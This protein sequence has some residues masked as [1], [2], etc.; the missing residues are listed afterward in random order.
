MANL[1]DVEGI[2]RGTDT[3]HVHVLHTCVRCATGPVFRQSSLLCGTEDLRC[4]CVIVA[5]LQML[6]VVGVTTL[7]LHV[8]GL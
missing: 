7:T 4:M 2:V 8:R 5:P 6:H 1:L 3:P